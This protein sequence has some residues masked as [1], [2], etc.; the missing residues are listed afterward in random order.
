MNALNDGGGM[1]GGSGEFGAAPPALRVAFDHTARF[2]ESDAIGS[3]SAVPEPAASAIC[4]IG[5]GV[6][7]TRRTAHRRR[8]D[9]VRVY[10]RADAVG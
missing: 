4:V 1:S 2:G 7:V 6:A 5:L 8:R 10:S 9:D 3:L